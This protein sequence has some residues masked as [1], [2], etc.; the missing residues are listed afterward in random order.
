MIGV[1]LT[2]LV[3]GVTVLVLFAGYCYGRAET[4][5]HFE[6]IVDE[7]QRTIDALLPTGLTL[8]P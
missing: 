5:A 2:G 6:P 3:C 1:A 7:L 8:R 4:E